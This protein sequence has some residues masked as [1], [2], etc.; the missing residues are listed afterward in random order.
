MCPKQS[1]PF[2]GQEFLWFSA[3]E[4]QTSCWT[5]CHQLLLA[6]IPPLSDLTGHPKRF[7]ILFLVPF[8]HMC[9][10]VQLMKT[11]IG[12]RGAKL[13]LPFDVQSL[14]KPSLEESV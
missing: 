13:A 3:L 12:F 10:I 4:V 1:R 14:I 5:S 2:P 6:E 9:S 8:S 7:V 11:L